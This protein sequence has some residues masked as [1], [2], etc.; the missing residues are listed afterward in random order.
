M[1]KLHLTELIKQAIWRFSMTWHYLLAIGITLL[2]LIIVTDLSLKNAALGFALLLL[3]FTLLDVPLE[4]E[5]FKDSKKRY[6]K[7]RPSQSDQKQIMAALIEALQDP[8]LILDETHHLILSNEAARNLFNV[9]ASGLDI[10]AIIRTPNFLEALTDVAETKASRTIQLLER[11]PVERHFSVTISWIAPQSKKNKIDREDD[12]AMMVYFQDLTEQERLNRMRSDFIA[13]ASHELRTPLASLL[14]FIETLQ[15]PARDD[16]AAREK[17]LKVMAAQGKRMTSLIDDLLSLSRI[18]MNDHKQPKDTVDLVN[19]LSNAIDVLAPLADEQNVT[20][21]LET[22]AENAVTK[23]HRDELL[24]VFQNLIH[25]AIK[26]GQTTEGENIIHIRLQDNLKENASPDQPINQGHIRIEIQDYG[27]GIDPVHI[28]RLTERF[29]RVDVQQS[30]EKGGTGLG[31]AIAKHIISHHQ[32]QLKIR[33][34]LG[35]G[36]TFSVTLPKA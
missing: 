33:S 10:S 30:R 20:I 18:E 1:N 12:L 7:H 21:K 25:N 11:V 27:I 22:V 6:K 32:G 34:K 3:C 2:F 23:G 36:S 28:P 8:V 4:H 5:K 35:E 26:Y 31:L 29:Y 24:Q 15:G 13:N 17:F 19:V 16:E 14:G 9:T